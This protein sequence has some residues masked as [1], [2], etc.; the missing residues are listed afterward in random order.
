M[1]HLGIHL[2]PEVHCYY[3]VT[4]KVV[5]IVY[6]ETTPYKY[7]LLRYVHM[8]P[9]LPSRDMKRML[10]RHLDFDNIFYFR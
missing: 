4:T 6:K 5:N 1:V 3:T 10:K 9:I 2:T 7:T 8:S